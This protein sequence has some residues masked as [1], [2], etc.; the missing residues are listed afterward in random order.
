MHLGNLLPPSIPMSEV[1]YSTGVDASLLQSVQA[2]LVKWK[3][4]LLLGQEVLRAR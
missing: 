4:D 1:N 2:L 3:V